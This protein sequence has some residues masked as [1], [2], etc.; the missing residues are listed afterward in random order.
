MPRI[1][2]G[3]AWYEVYHEI[4]QLLLKF[5][6]KNGD[7]SGEK[8]FELLNSSS[9]YRRNNNWLL[10][11]KRI[12]RPSLEPIQVFVSFSRAGQNVEVRIRLI[13][14]VLRLLGKRNQQLLKINFEGC[15]TPFAL[16]LQ[17]I[18][19]PKVQAEIWNTFARIMKNDRKALTRDLWSK[20]KE[21]RGIQIPSFT[22]FLFW[23]NSRKFLPLDK[24]TKRYL[25]VCEFIKTRDTIT[26]DLY[27][28]LLT[29]IKLINYTQLST[30]AYY[31]INDEKAFINKFGKNS[32]VQNKGKIDTTFRLIGFRT[33]KRNSTVHK[34]IKP[35]KYY[36]LDYTI[37]PTEFDNKQTNCNSFILNPLKTENLYHLENLKVNITAI[38]GKN[39]SGKSTLLDIL[40]MAIYNLSIELKYLERSENKSI[41]SL[42][43]EIYWHTDTLY[44]L[45][46][47]KEIKFFS[48]YKHYQNDRVTRF[49]LISKNLGLEE[50][51]VNFFYSILVNY[52]HYALNSSDYKIDW[53]T[54][55]SHKNDG[56]ITPIVI[57]PKRTNGN[58][59]V[60]NEKDLLNMRLLLNFLELHDSDIP[61]Q[62]F[63]YIDNSKQVKYFSLYN[64]TEKQKGIE[65]EVKKRTYEDPKIVKMIIQEVF[66]VFNLDERKVVLAYNYKAIETYISYKLFS[67][68]EKYKRYSDNFETIIANLIKHNIASTVEGMDEEY[69]KVLRY[70][71]NE[72]LTNIKI[73]K[74]HIT[75][76]LRQ[77]I[78]HIKYKA[79]NTV[80]HDAIK[81]ENKIELDKYKLTIDKIINTSLEDN[82]TVAELL[83]PPIYGLEFYFDDAD[84]S[85]LKKAS[86]GEY[87]LISV[88][89]SILYHIRNIDSII[90]N[91][92]NY[93]TVFL[94]EI[95][96]YF[97]PNMQR[98]FIRKLLDAISKL[99]TNLYGIN[100]LFSTHSPFILSDI[101]Q[102]K[103]LK[104]NKGEIAKTE[105]GYNTFAA[106]IHDL[107]SDEF[108]LD[109]GS[110][111][112]FAQRQIEIVINIL[113]YAT[114]KQEVDSLIKENNN[115]KERTI[116]KKARIIELEN[117]KKILYSQKYWNEYRQPDNWVFEEEKEGI[118]GI[119]EL[120]GEPVIKGK[121]LSMFHALIPKTDDEKKHDAK[122]EI[123]RLMEENNIYHQDLQ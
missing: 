7:T 87:Q 30:E 56:Y 80:L 19:S 38:V 40:L 37:I 63:R 114:V 26:Y 75:L 110:M 31:Y 41:A 70:K 53:I 107:L 28:S 106:N 118:R 108:F 86:S 2:Q 89:S 14:E 104:L 64:N 48:F 4:A 47:G 1:F 43:F 112:A 17:Y 15:P 121:L 101:Q 93:A 77:A 120:I 82:L 78:N 67:I 84:F 111:G 54:P 73:D 49:E 27:K 25:E 36:P 34:V 10:N 8:L 71:F 68:I 122:Q 95:E 113:N 66:N 83:P 65:S 51:N 39:G 3:M 103:I 50:L 115:L 57:N 35:L 22:I 11:M 99:E 29:N 20:V 123:L 5:Y 6:D 85:N 91:R 44:K 97:H 32:L 55:L 100:I 119:I 105:N 74:S 45:V 98:F 61:D 69:E 13:T 60:N 58:I 18:R 42:N 72:L 116:L 96:L 33:L 23:I 109:E 24:N 81:E 79:L 52:S 102:Q 46:F 88:L 62:S 21:W 76:K 92:Y 59:D 16:K 90:E 12:E 117:Y 94:D 9:L